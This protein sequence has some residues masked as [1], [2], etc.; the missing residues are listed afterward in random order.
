MPH[1]LRPIPTPGFLRP[2]IRWATRVSLNAP[3]WV[4]VAIRNAPLRMT[5][6]LLRVYAALMR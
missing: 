4:P 5:R 6:Y 3:Q 2:V 1:K